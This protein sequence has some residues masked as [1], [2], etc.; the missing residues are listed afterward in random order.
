MLETH[1]ERHGILEPHVPV[2]LA[3]NVKVVGR[4]LWEQ[5]EPIQQELV[6]VL[7]Y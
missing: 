4:K 2:R 5:L 6:V 7:G 3:S 1:P